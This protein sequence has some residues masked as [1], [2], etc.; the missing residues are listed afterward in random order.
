MARLSK[1]LQSNSA[2][3]KLHQWAP[4]VE[5][6]W[7]LAQKSLRKAALSDMLIHYPVAC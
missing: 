4:E 6:H 3:E 1:V 5:G 2:P 7:A